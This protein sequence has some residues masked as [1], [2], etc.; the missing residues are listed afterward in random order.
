MSIVANILKPET[1]YVFEYPQFNEIADEQLKIFWPW[2][3]IKV[4]KDK[5]DL[6]TKLTEAEQ[7]AVITTL[8]L[9]T[10]YELYVGNEY[11]TSRI[12]KQFQRPEIQRMAT[13]FANVELNSHAPF[14]AKINIE[15]GLSTKEFYEAYTNDPVLVDRMAFIQKL[16]DD[17]DNFISIAGFSMVEGAVLYSSFAFL[18]HFQSNGKNLIPNIIRGINMSARDEN[19]HALASA[20]LFRILLE[21][22][23]PQEKPLYIKESALQ[24]AQSIYEHEA[25]II[26]MLFEAGPIKGCDRFELQQFVKSRINH[27]L[28]NLGYQSIYDTEFNPIADWFYVGI[29]NYMMNDFFQGIGREYRRGW[30]PLGFVW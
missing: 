5:Q 15:L 17:S 23:Y 18:K 4:E 28:S 8:K 27:C 19:L 3:E 2:N 26:D 13:C 12:A 9:F 16:V 25:R 22:T 30:N 24:I 29:N 10:K 21:E 14:Y 1:A 7:H 6:L 20:Q 11:W